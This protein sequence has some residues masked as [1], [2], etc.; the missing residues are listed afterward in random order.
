VKC[1]VFLGSQS[2]WKETI[3]SVGAIRTIQAPLPNCIEVIP[4]RPF[5]TILHGNDM[6]HVVNDPFAFRN[7]H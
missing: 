3:D 4:V 5:P 2:V 1:W 7:G 6:R